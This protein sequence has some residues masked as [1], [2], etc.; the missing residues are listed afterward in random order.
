[1]AVVEDKANWAPSLEKFI[2]KLC[3]IAEEA[4]AAILERCEI[5]MVCVYSNCKNRSGRFEYTGRKFAGS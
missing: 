4:H 1:M 3:E 5:I 2:R